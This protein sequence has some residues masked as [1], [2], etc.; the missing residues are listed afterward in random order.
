MYCFNVHKRI[1]LKKMPGGLVVTFSCH[2]FGVEG[3][4]GIYINGK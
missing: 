3:K 4:Y 2:L 1:T